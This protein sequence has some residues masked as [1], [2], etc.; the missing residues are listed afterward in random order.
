MSL[1]PWECPPQV[2]SCGPGLV[3]PL[4]LPLPTRLTSV[5]SVLS[6]VLSLSLP[7]SSASLPCRVNPHLLS[8]PAPLL[9][10]SSSPGGESNSTSCHRP[11]FPRILKL[12]PSFPPMPE[13]LH[14]HFIHKV[15]DYR[16][17]ITL[18]DYAAL[19][20][21]HFP[22]EEISWERTTHLPHVICHPERTTEQ[23][24]KPRLLPLI[25]VLLRPLPWGS[26]HQG[27]IPPPPPRR[28]ALR[29]LGC[30]VRARGV[31]HCRCFIW[32][33][34][35]PG[36]GGVGESLAAASFRGRASELARS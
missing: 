35:A 9:W 31:G 16:T 17:G 19:P 24:H 11:C 10:A 2:C 21:P 32:S 28:P 29:R 23:N 27:W 6:L 33:M 26:T 8:A 7:C 13:F 22:A 3:W 5:L 4:A 34:G 18:R 20:H 25:P 12:P 36:H 14:F 30:C 1:Y 15:M